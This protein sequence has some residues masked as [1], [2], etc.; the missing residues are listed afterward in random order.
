LAFPCNQ[1]LYQE[2][3]GADDIR[4]C[5]VKRFNAQ[6]TIF[7]KIN[8]NGSNMHPV[9]AFL[10]HHFPGKIPWNFGAIFIVDKNGHPLRRFTGA[11]WEK[12][13]EVIKDMVEGK[14]VPEL[15]EEEH[16]KIAL[17]AEKEA[18]DNGVV[19]SPRPS[20]DKDGSFGFS[21]SP[22][23]VAAAPPSPS[24]SPV[25]APAA[26]PAAA[27]VAAPEAAAESAAAP[28]A[29]P[30]V[31]PVAAAPAAAPVAAPAPAGE[32]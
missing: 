10:Q 21:A 30:A 27:P 11:N 14:A 17:S 2:P 24:A 22:T 12:V 15:S 20:S 7:D 13:E 5:A 6:F 9:Y 8:V 29:A 3:G 19:E 4:A 1:F 28:V 18:L 23:P 16:K 25:A 31:A 26:A 32:V